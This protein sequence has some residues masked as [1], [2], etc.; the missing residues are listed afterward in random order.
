MKNKR[1][2][3]LAVNTLVIIILGILVLIA[4]LIFWNYQTGI[5]SDFLKNFG[6]KSNVDVL[7]TSCN[8]IVSQ[9]AVYEFCCVKRETRYE[10]DNEFVKEQ[11]TCK[12][13]RDKNFSGGRIQEFGCEN[14]GC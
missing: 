5:F 11:L 8:T 4:I 13:L 14:A 7:V 10:Q 2:M 12:E 9:Q 1:G 3:E 6:G